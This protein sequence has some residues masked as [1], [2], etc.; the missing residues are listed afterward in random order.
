M[1]TNLESRQIAVLSCLIYCPRSEGFYT[2]QNSTGAKVGTAIWETSDLNC[3][4]E[5]GHWGS[6]LHVWAAWIS[7]HNRGAA[8]K[9]GTVLPRMESPTPVTEALLHFSASSQE[10]DIIMFKQCSISDL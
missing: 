6:E 7:D 1:E 9:W 10:Q 4:I 2:G 3:K 5:A 8:S